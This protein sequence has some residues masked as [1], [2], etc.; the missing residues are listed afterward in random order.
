MGLDMYLTKR[1]SVKGK[2]GNVNLSEIGI[3]NFWDEEG[4][5]IINPAKMDSIILDI[6]YWRK[7]NQI[8]RWF[9]TNCQDG[10]DDCGLHEVSKEQ[11][12]ELLSLCKTVLENPEK[13]P[14]LLPTTSGFFFGNTDYG[15]YYTED[16][17]NTINMLQQELDNPDPEGYYYYQS[18]W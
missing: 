9:V 16:I 12:E 11:L 17:Q 5:L 14:E 10:K 18:S 6:A 13:A 8:H 1:V 15:D 4:D 3:V 7:A 2:E